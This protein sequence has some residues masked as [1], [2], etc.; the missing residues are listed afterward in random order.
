MRPTCLPVA[1][2]LLLCLAFPVLAEQTYMAITFDE[3]AV[4]Q[5]IGT[6]GVLIGEPTWVDSQIEA[7]VRA[8]PFATPSLEIHNVDYTNPHAL[9]FQMVTGAPSTGLVVIVTDLWFEETGFGSE[10]YIEIYKASWYYLTR[11]RF[12]LDGTVRITDPNGTV[13]GPSF[14]KGRATPLLVAFDMDAGT[15]SVWIDEA[16]VVADRLHGVADPDFGIILFNTGYG[17]D[18]ANRFWV[19]QIRVI[20]W[21]PD[22]IAS[23]P[24]SWGRIRAL[25]R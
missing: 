17:D 13:E 20:D 9:G 10:P 6:G 12:C 15:Y 5:P 24:A 25:Y 14:P 23:L 3:K 16:P 7:I 1:C 22:D 8:T 4:D 21:L 18:P 19:D 11:V 2:A